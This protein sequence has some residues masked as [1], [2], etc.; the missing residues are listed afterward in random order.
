M[1][2]PRHQ[3]LQDSGEPPAARFPLAFLLSVPVSFLSSVLQV[4]VKLT[5]GR[6]RGTLETELRKRVSDREAGGQVQGPQTLG[7]G[8]QVLT[9]AKGHP[10]VIAASPR[11][12]VL[13]PQTPSRGPAAAHRRPPTPRG[14]GSPRVG[15]CGRVVL[16]HAAVT[17]G[18]AQ[19]QRL[20]QRG[21]SCREVLL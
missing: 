2:G 7:S 21:V 17:P 16:A 4:F 1:R 3:R 13:T 20:G 11:G 10:C 12:R 14:N 19:G 9:P 5:V 18:H 6:L 15:F 8:R